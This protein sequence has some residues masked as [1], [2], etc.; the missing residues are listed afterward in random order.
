MIQR[1]R[2]LSNWLKSDE[3]LS[4]I[5]NTIQHSNAS[6]AESAKEIFY[7]VSSYLKL[8][9][10][11][12]D[13]TEA[14]CKEAQESGVELESVFEQMAVVNYISEGKEDKRNLVMQ[15]LYNVYHRKYTALENA[16]EIYFGGVDKIPKT[17]T[18][19]LFGTDIDA[20]IEFSIK[21]RSWID[22]GA[23]MMK[24]II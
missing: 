7:A 18:C 13:I 24:K 19:Y 10:T 22:A 6:I 12:E 20:R 21:E 3:G 14:M 15:A 8:P 1:S 17:Y 16:A 5:I 9:I 2:N 23:K 11:P 4:D